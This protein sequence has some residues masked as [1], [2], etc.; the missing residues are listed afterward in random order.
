MKTNV[1][2]HPDGHSIDC[3]DNKL[4]AVDSDGN[5]VSIPIGTYG[6]LLLADKLE[7]VAN[8]PPTKGN[9]LTTPHSQPAKTLTKYAADF[10]TMVARSATAASDFYLDHAIGFD[11]IAM[12]ILVAVFASLKVTQ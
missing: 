3:A 6:L 2:Q 9:G 7:S 11:S 5:S 10:T 1:Y 8:G 4:T 12:L